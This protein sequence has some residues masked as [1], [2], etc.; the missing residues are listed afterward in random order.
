MAGA[1]GRCPSARGRMRAYDCHELVGQDASH[2][3][4][5]DGSGLV[6]RERSGARYNVVMS[7]N[8]RKTL[9][10]AAPIT[11]EVAAVRDRSRCQRSIRSATFLAGS[12]QFARR[13][14]TQLS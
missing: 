11:P 6:E 5:A 14:H 2:H 8:G 10:E 4:L 3:Q 7:D 13:R 1:V 12:R 9:E